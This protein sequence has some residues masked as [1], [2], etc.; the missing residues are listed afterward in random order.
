MVNFYL[1]WMTFTKYLEAAASRGR[2]HLFQGKL[3]CYIGL[4]HAVSEIK[5]SNINIS[6]GP[7]T[8][9]V[10]MKW[11]SAQ[12]M[13]TC[14]V[15]QWLKVSFWV[16]TCVKFSPR[17]FIFPWCVDFSS[18]TRD[19]THT[20]SRGSAESWPLDCQGIPGLFR[21]FVKKK[22]K[23]IHTGRGNMLQFYTHMCNTHT[24]VHTHTHTELKSHRR[25][26]GWP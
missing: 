9:G 10:W 21:E 20:T 11:N 16:R 14:L 23:K 24:H 2:S 26:Q 18:L 12:A 5:V 17:K 6:F 3:A 22:K 19:T 4:I 15:W 1:K 8:G 25:K 13:Y 7:S